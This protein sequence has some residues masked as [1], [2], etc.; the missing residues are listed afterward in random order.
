[1]KPPFRDPLIRAWARLLA[2]TATTTLLAGV[3]GWPRAV[4]AAILIVAFF[5]ARTILGRF[6]HLDGAPGWLSGVSAVIAFW[7]AA[8]WVLHAV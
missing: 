6:L 1:M 3:G 8:I 4:A 7:L 5:K 2:L